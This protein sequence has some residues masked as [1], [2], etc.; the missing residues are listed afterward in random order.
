MAVRDYVFRDDIYAELKTRIGYNILEIPKIIKNWA[1]YDK[2]EILES[3]EMCELNEKMINTYR[4]L[5]N[6]WPAAA[7][8]QE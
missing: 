6:Q 2:E 4:E 7:C 3:F 1:T 8:L 5:Y